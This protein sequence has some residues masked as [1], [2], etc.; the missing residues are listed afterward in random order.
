MVI[1]LNITEN[2]YRRLDFLSYSSIKYFIDDR[3]KFYRKFILKQEV[4]DEDETNNSALRMGSLVD[5]LLFTPENLD[6][7]FTLSKVEVPTGQ[8]Y[9]FTMNLYNRTLLSIDKNGVL[10]K[11]INTLMIEA[12]NDTKFDNEGNHVAFKRKNDTVDKIKEKFLLSCVDFY[13]E[14]RNRGDKILIS[15]KELDQANKLVNILKTHKYTKEVINSTTSENQVM[16]Q[17]EVEGV[18]LKCMIDKVVFDHQEKKIH[19]YDLKTTWNVDDFDNNY[20]KYRYYI[21]NAVYTQLMMDYAKENYPGYQ[22]IP[23]SF[24]VV[25]KLTYMDPIIYETHFDHFVQAGRGFVVENE[26]YTGLREALKNIKK[27]QQTG[28]WNS[29]VDVQIQNGRRL[30]KLY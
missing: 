10:T 24:I 14:L 7:K 9:N 19:L 15:S 28:N 16:L 11:D 4:K 17:G 26:S 18:Q 30:I 23:L 13:Q 5:C 27:H 21:Q 3:K 25:D 20:L 8:M 29:S 2:E 1:K 12:Y 22:V 6:D